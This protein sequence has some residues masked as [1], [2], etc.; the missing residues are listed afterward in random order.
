MDITQSL[1]FQLAVL[2]LIMSLGFLL[3]RLRVVR[4]EDSRIL[5]MLTIYLIQPCVII[6]AF[7]INYEPKV[8]DGYLLAVGV[9]IA[10]NLLLLLL[11]WFFARVF[12]LDAVE[13]TSI[14]YAN[15][16]NLII[17][18]VESVL[19]SAMG[20][21]RIIYASAFMC[22]QLVFIWTHGQAQISGQKAW[23]WR[24]ILGNVNLIAVASGLVL[25]LA[26]VR[27]PGIIAGA[28]DQL[29]AT[30]GPVTMIMIG[31]LLADVPWA[32]ILRAPRNYL[33]VAL[34]MMVTPLIILL[35]LK[36]SGVAGMHP[37]GRII[38]YISFMAVITPC[39]ATVTQLAQ[40]YR[41]R[42]A[43]AGALNA[44]TMLTSIV[45]MP[46]MTWL[47]WLIP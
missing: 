47:Y 42:P 10:V 40:I 34:K 36:I 27:L 11:T 35:I 28:F 39:A 9:A 3:V 43:Y 24:K 30:M 12:H 23:S 45:T 41:N 5:S 13:R 19:G 2:F 18:L 6:R 38:V 33:I 8:R 31:M 21:E 32:E 46:L 14:M 25:L 29:S 7:Q 37:Q 26:G 20:D 1:L 16:G 15:A 4:S 22:V 17:P 44:L